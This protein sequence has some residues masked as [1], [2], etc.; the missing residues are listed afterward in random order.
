MSLKAFIVFR[1]Q[2]DIS[3]TYFDLFWLV[4]TTVREELLAPSSN[5]I[6][7][8]IYYC[9]FSATIYPFSSN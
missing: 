9:V 8:F 3:K 4:H 6:F 1:A 2:K 5:G 7:P